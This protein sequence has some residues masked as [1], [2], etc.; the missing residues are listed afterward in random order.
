MKEQCSAQVVPE[1]A[2]TVTHQRR[3]VA[4]RR[5]PVSIDTSSTWK[6]A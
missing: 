2:A 1:V 3:R 5:L 4:V 6:V